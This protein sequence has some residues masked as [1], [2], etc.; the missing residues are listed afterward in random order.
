MSARRSSWFAPV[1]A[2][3]AFSS[4]QLHAQAVGVLRG[5][6]TD[7]SSALVPDASVT[8]TNSSTGITR[9]VRTNQQGIF[10]LPDIPI[11]SYSLQIIK[12]G[13]RTEQRTGIELLTGQVADLSFKLSLGEASQ[14]VEVTEGAALLQTSSS[15]VQTTIDAK[16]ISELPLNGRNPLQLTTLTPGTALTATGTEA[17]QQD[18]TGLVVNGLRPTQSTYLL[19]NAIYNNRFFD[20]VPILPNPDALQEFTIQSS[21]YSAEFPGAGALVQLSTRS[22][23]NKIHGSAYEFLRN[24]VLNA[25]NRFPARSASGVA[26]KPPFKLNQFGGTVGG[27]IL[28][29]RTFF[30]F[31]A[32]NLEQRSSANPVSFVIP[33]AAQMSGDFSSLISAGTQIYNPATGTPYAGNRIN[34]G[35]SPL[36]QAVY[37]TYLAGLGPD[38]TGR[39]TL[40][41]NQNVSSTQYLV[42]I[43]HQVAKNNHFSGRYF[44]NQHNF[45]R[46][47]T[48]P[49][50]FFAANAFRN[51][52]L[53]LSDTHIFSPTLTG[54]VTIAGGRFARTQ[55]PQAP[56][57]QSLQNLGQ[58]VPL[59]TPISLFPGIRANIA[60]FVNIFS[61]GTLAQAAT[62]FDYKIAFV[63]IAGSHAISFGG[64]WE[65]TRINANDFSFVP[66][67][68]VFSGARTA[69]PTGTALPTGFRSSGNAVADFYLGYESTF[70]QDNGRTMYLRENRPALYVQDDWKAT[71]DLTINA[72]LR[73]DPWLPPHDLNDSLV[74][75]QAGARSTVAP[76][77]PVGLQF[78]GDR[79]LQN[80]IFPKKFKNFGPRVGFAYNVGGRS[81]IVIRGAYGLF[82]GFPEGLLYQRTNQTQPRNFALS[83]SNPANSWDNIFAGT[84]SPFPRA[85][86]PVGQ[87]GTY[88]FTLPVAGG[89]LDPNSKVATIQDRNLTVE[90]QLTSSLAVSLAYVGNHVQHIMGSRQLNPA[91]YSP[92]ATLANTQARRIYQGLGAVEIASS[93]EYADYNGLQ[94]NVTRRVSKGLHVLTNLTWAK[95]IDNTSSAIEGNAGPANPFDLNSSR[96]PADYDVKLRY[97]LSLV[98]DIPSAHVSRWAGAVINGWQVNTIFSAS[99][100]SPFTVLSGTDRSLS[101]IGGDYADRVG[102]PGRPAN[103]TSVT[104]YFNTSAYQAAATGTFGNSGR[105]SLRGPGVVNLDA[106]AAKTFKLTDRFNLQFHTQAF[107]AI[108]RANLNNPNATA[109]SG[110]ASFG[111]ITSAA[112]PR[113]LQ[114]ALRT[115][116]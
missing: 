54:T 66:G 33:T 82:Y 103:A 84:T 8:A 56:G 51:Q 34:S 77:A 104:Q 89:V 52:S 106:S 44:Y 53:V 98:Y 109:S 62:T 41:P 58:Q 47:F 43:D 60:G 16:Q 75:F 46:S 9:T 116:F 65:R 5:T 38:S 35:A 25:Y 21:N 42:K 107:N 23:T 115:T 57:L 73:W 24:T 4:T 96:G 13:F 80:S 88:N 108:N 18:N 17:G 113:V 71:R 93:Y 36:S 2:T 40:S 12:D 68:N 94:L 86:T 14:T 83:I 92:T 87:F 61:G 55:V 6:V 3:I 45:Q 31:G 11:G 78:L 69:A 26:I 72:G 79:G 111:R 28:K 20:S 30:F 49:T 101:G 67:D 85:K 48:A 112:S 32:E 95:I 15:S 97:N 10:V 63:K 39:V 81:K 74:G 91:V 19:D 100:G 1:L 27:P 114:F 90:A 99:T 59:G 22:G 7:A 50:G 64:E 29:D 70:S 110:T 102:D 105:N 76:N 37:R